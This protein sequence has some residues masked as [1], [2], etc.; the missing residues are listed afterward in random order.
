MVA[1]DKWDMCFIPDPHAA[2]GDL[3]CWTPPA[4]LCLPHPPKLLLPGIPTFQMPGPCPPLKFPHRLFMGSCHRRQPRSGLRGGFRVC[5][6][7][8]VPGV[9]LGVGTV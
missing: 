8:L 6:V 5:T 1:S 2:P 4:L 3:L 7:G 9:A